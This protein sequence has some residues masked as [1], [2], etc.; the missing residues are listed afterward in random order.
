M[1]IYLQLLM[2]IYLL[3]TTIDQMLEDPCQTFHCSAKQGMNLVTNRIERTL[4]Y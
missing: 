1:S 2:I 4:Q 3:L